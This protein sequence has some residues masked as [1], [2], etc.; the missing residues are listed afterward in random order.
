M[1]VSDANLWVLCSG[2]PS[3]T[4]AET[5]GRLVKINTGTNSVAQNFNFQDTEHPG[6]LCIDGNLLL[7]ALNG[8]VYK[9]DVDAADLPTTPSSITGFFYG[10]T[11]NNGRLYATDAGDFASNGT[12]KV[13]D[14]ST[15]TEIQSI[16]VGI[17]PGGIYFN[18]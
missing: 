2:A 13:Y 4:G 18:E 12:L 6:S 10:M 8:G 3:F 1:V 17:I 16:G 5:P 15:D 14:L 11:A 7:Y 9:L